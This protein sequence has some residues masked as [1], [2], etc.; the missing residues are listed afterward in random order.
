[1]VR[2]L[3]T[4]GAGYIGSHVVKA[5]GE[6]ECEILVF[7][8]LSTGHKEAVLY[9]ELA[10]GDVGDEN[11]LGRVLTDFKPDVV[12]HFAAFI[13]VEESVRN[14]V[15]YYENNFC[16]TVKLLKAMRAA[17]VDKF[18]FSSSAAVY[19]EPDEVPIGEG[20]PFNPVN[21]Y[22]ASKAFVERLLK[23]LSDAGDFRYV[24][25]RYFNAA[26]AD[27]EGRIG[28]S[29]KR[30]TH[31]I[32]RALKVA[33]GEFEKLYIYGTDYPTPDGTCIRDYIHV[34]DL[35]KAHVLALDYLLSGGESRAF[36]CGYGRGYSVKEVIETAKKVTKVDFPVEEA[37][38]RPGDP[39]VLI[40]DSSRIRGALSWEPEYDD[41][42]FIIKTAWNWELNKRF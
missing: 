4:G 33:K 6:R 10:E 29:Y 27:P 36:N 12:M 25:L 18:I 5:L 14:P 30:A 23:E 16:N 1:M 28:Q 8:N 24:S 35:A 20:A 32:T 2:V 11:L 15:K 13:E 42:E 39:A 41:L 34:D 22:G 17:G 38:R 9:G 21:P 37:A 40:A 7:D 19:G 26:G 3:V 31:L